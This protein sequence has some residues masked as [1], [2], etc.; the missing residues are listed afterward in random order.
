MKI[1][2]LS[3]LHLEIANMPKNYRPPE[4]DVVILAGDIAPGRQGAAWAMEAFP[5]TLPVLYVPGNHEYYGRSLRLIEELRVKVNA[6]P[7]VRML[8]REAVTLN[9]VRFIGA[10]L[11]TD[12]GLY[13]DSPLIQARSAANARFGMNDFFQIEGFSVQTWIDHN[14][15]G[16]Q[17]IDRELRKAAA[18]EQRAVVITHHAPHPLSVRK[19]WEE[20]E[21]NPA[22]ASRL[23]NEL[24]VK[25]DLWVHGHM[26][27]SNDYRVDNTRVVCNARGYWGYPPGM[28]NPDFDPGLV[29]EIGDDQ[30]GSSARN[31]D[32]IQK[33]DS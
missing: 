1:H 20:D 14:V 7:N 11:W 13:G 18:H 31:G 4:C 15:M 21:L 25:P 10:T 33:P 30:R 2:I 3:D 5:K 29:V 17:F 26:H 8:D 32:I 16:A 6:T 24:I 19:E 27:V 28:S 23:L 9:G 12:F 22:Y